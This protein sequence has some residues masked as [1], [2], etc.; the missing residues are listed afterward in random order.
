MWYRI[1]YHYFQAV[2]MLYLLHDI[3]LFSI[4]LGNPFIIYL[5]MV[6]KIF[7]LVSILFLYRPLATTETSNFIPFA[8]SALT[9]NY[10][11]EL[12]RIFT[13]G[14]D[15]QL[16]ILGDDAVKAW[17]NNYA[18]SNLQQEMGIRNEAWK[19]FFKI[20]I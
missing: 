14:G 10:K 2:R 4:K 6:K 1:D 9:V 12:H 20:N 5:R 16:K 17:K 13:A 15:I 11:I 19:I 18:A 7:L 3:Y 8:N